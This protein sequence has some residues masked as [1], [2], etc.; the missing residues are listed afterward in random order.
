MYNTCLY[1]YSLW[2]TLYIPR[3]CACLCVCKWVRRL[4]VG[5]MS[6]YLP[7]YIY[8]VK[9]NMKTSFDAFSLFERQQIGGRHVIVLWKR[10]G[11]SHHEKWLQGHS[12]HFYTKGLWL[13]FILSNCMRSALHKVRTKGAKNDHLTLKEF[14]ISGRQKGKHTVA[15]KPC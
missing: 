4:P 1:N 5:I 11:E 7:Q 3:P 10:L 2:I 8:R 15:L 6:S 9:W 12:N 13:S 14:R